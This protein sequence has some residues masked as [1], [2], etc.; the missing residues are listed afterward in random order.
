MKT[1]RL[2][3][4]ANQ[5]SNSSCGM[6]ILPMRHNPARH[7]QDAHATAGFLPVSMTLIP[8]SP[9][10]DQ[11]TLDIRVGVRNGDPAPRAF[12]VSVFLDH[13]EPGSCLHRERIE[14]AGHQAAGLKFRW[15]TAGH[16]GS[17]TVLAV[18]ACGDDVHRTSRPLRILPSTIRSTETIGGAWAGLYHWSDSEGLHWNTDLKTM[19]GDQWRELVRGMHE[20]GMDIINIQE[21]FRNEEYAGKHHIEVEGYKGQAFYPSA[22]YPGRMPIAA[23]DPLEAIFDEAD[24]LGM[25]VLP[26]IG[27]YAWFDYSPASLAWHIR[28]ADEIWARY[29]HHPSFY[30]WK[31]S[32]EGHGGLGFGI[33]STG[34]D[35][36]R[37]H[38]QL[39]EFFRCFGAHVR[40]LAPD[41]PVMVA[42]STHGMRGAEDTYRELLKHLD[43]LCSF[44][45]HRMPA[46]DM[47]G[48]EAA[49]MLQSLC[50]EAG[51][52]LWMNMEVF[53]FEGGG[54]CGAPLIPRPIAGVRE[55]MLRFPNFEKI[56][57][58]QYPGL[59]T[60][61]GASVKLGGPAAVGL[62]QDY[63]AYLEGK[64]QS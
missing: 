55:D 29:G 50:D 39:V 41:K 10:T 52:H 4:I 1:N 13:E 21:L 34:A 47:T 37:E 56:L 7:G 32:E 14:V 63:A 61:P 35:L 45:F 53:L 58:Y 5:A 8:P 11:I 38:R 27:M 23:A 16:G 28:V 2:L 12:E 15:P 26:G 54:D 42:R 18:V 48:D 36:E 25:S 30:G 59:M 31:I 60:H 43:I 46:D 6:G 57:C 17:H 64:G 9:V 40:R 62:Y 51:A 3:T 24:K 44:C 49:A 20:I 22:L 19:S 33:G